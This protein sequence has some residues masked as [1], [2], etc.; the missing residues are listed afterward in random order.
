MEAYYNKETRELI[1]TD[2]RL[3]Y[4]TYLYECEDRAEIIKSIQKDLNLKD[5]RREFCVLLTNDNQSDE[6]EPEII[7]KP[8]DTIKPGLT[9]GEPEVTK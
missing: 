2:K 4:H 8:T 7:E 1:I 6:T 9:T 3:A 5:E